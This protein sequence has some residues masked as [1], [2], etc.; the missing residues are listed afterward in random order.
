MNQDDIVKVL[1]DLLWSLPES[2]RPS[3]WHWFG[4]AAETQSYWT[5]AVI[6][7]LTG[8][9]YGCVRMYVESFAE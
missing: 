2:V 8:I 5:G 6:M 7:A 9:V 3:I 1:L 4:V